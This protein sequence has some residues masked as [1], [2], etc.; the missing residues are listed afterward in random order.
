[1]QFPIEI[2][3][4]ILGVQL[5]VLHMQIHMQ[6]HRK[7][8]PPGFRTSHLITIQGLS[9]GLVQTKTADMPTKPMKGRRP[10]LVELSAVEVWTKP[11][12]DRGIYS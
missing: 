10:G 2:D 11:M 5:V 12:T 8:T 4:F 1:M 3:Y 7:M 9:Y 6:I